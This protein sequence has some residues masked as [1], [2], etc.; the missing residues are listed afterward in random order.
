VGLS[1]RDILFGVPGAA[2][3]YLTAKALGDTGASDTRG[4][5]FAH[6]TD[7]HM[8][9]QKGPE[10]SFARA[11]EHAQSRGAE[12]IVNGGDAIMDASDTERKLV[13]TYWSA[14]NRILQQH[15]SLPVA[16]VLGNHDVFGW[17]SDERRIEAKT[18]TFQRLGMEQP[19]Y[20]FDRGG[21]KLIVLDSIGWAPE[22]PRGYQAMLGLE[23]AQ[24]LAS[25]IEST[26]L[27]VCIISHIPLL[28]VCAFFDGR[29][30]ESGNWKVPG[31][32]MH[33]DSRDIKELFSRHPQVKLCLSGHIHLV[34]NVKYANVDYYCNGAVSGYYWKG[35][36]QGFGPA[37]ALVD[38]LPDGSYE[39][40]MVYY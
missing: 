33:L 10:R 7:V 4:F 35:P 25:E 31:A 3:G 8:V 23:Q 21:W 16:N 36:Y 28:S 6:L 14:Y 27:P 29:N 26:S 17:A 2:V 24:W 19:Y 34:D 11:L 9:A 20:S 39:H 12:L 32:W 38:L 15:N 40:E 30:E 1:R 37:Y 5:R 18:E 13:E 22:R